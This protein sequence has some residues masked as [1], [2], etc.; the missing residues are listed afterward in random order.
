[1]LQQWIH[2]D[3]ALCVLKGTQQIREYLLSRS[4][5]KA[6]ECDRHMMLLHG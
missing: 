5:N 4:A 3:L 2:A 6:L 1:M